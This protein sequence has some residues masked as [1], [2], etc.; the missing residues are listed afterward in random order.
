MSELKKINEYC[1]EVPRSGDMRV[2]GRIYTDESMVKAVHQDGTVKQVSNVAT[3]PGI[4]RASFAMPDVHQGYGFPIGG[5][6]AFDWEEGIVSPGGVGYDISCLLSDARI[7][8]HHGYTFTISEMEKFWP[9]SSLKCRDFKEGVENTTP[10]VGY[11]K[12]PPQNPVYRLTTT[13]GDDILAT[14]DHPFWTPGGMVELE[15][16]TV[17]DNIARYPFEGVPYQAPDNEILVDEEA[18]RSLLAEQGK[19][20]GG[21]ALAQVLNQLKKRDL[22]PLRKDSP[23]LPYLI[24]LAGF[25]M[26]DGCMY[27]T[28]G[29]GKGRT[30]FF[31]EEADLEEIRADV[32]MTGFTPSRIYRRERNHKIRTSYGEFEFKSEE[33]AFKVAGSAF[34]SLLAAIGTPIGRKATQDFCVP[35]WLFNAPRWQ[36]RLFLAAYFGAELSLPKASP[37]K[38]H[39]FSTPILSM[40]KREGFIKSG[41]RFLE[42]I[43]KLLEGFG[44]ET[45]KI[46]QRREQINAD[47]SNS[48]RLRLIFSSKP[49]SLINLWRRVGFEYNRKRQNLGMLAIEYLRQKVRILNRRNEIAAQAIAMAAADVSFPKIFAQL[50]GQGHNINESFLKRAILDERST[51]ARIGMQFETF[52]EFCNHAATGITDSGMVWGTIESLETVDLSE[53]KAYDGYV[54]DFTVAHPDHNFIANGFVVSNCGVRLAT[55]HLEEKDVTPKV[56]ELVTALYQGIPCGVGSKGSVRLS[57]DE[58]KKVLRQGSQWAVKNGFGEKSDIEHTEEGGCLPDADPEL[59]SDRALQRGKKQLGTLGSGNHFIEVGVVEEVF[60]SEA[61]RVFGLFEGQVTVMLHSGSRGLGHQIC[62]DY[63]AFMTKHVKNLPIELPDR[64]LACAMIQSE[65][66]KR[67]LSAMACGANYA[68]AN[69]QIMM[70]KSREIFLQFFGISPRNL[71]MTLLYDVCHNIAKKETHLVDG[72]ER[73]LCVHRK[74]ATRAFPALHPAVPEVYRQMGQPVII[75]GDMGTASYVLVGTHKAMEETFGSTCHGAGRVLSRTAAKKKAK[76]RAIYR[77]LEEKGIFVKSKGKHTMAEE[78]PEAY[79]DISQVIEVVHGAGISKKVAKL[80]PIAVVKG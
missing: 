25:V 27:F 22:L 15:R 13:G 36:Q 19:G 32:R 43:S 39:N 7:L 41:T 5:V 2:P 33:T 57:I 47:G 77:E 65:E 34:A 56:K 42:D 23:Q 60:D 66:G 28:G 38:N 20:D 64:Q 18:V 55:T 44:V 68:W 24:K 14:A 72:K 1:W 12:I 6:A 74:G 50:A 8:N 45:K 35:Q 67:Y 11:L 21:N 62:D 69:R 40:N 49:E 4:V 61:A 30:W 17:G 63:L 73:V 78:M 71:G 26:G 31:G 58:E 51:G 3:L 80:R 75:P 70:H 54:Y 37:K 59:I 46:S 48:H 79:K 29:S 76:G 16:L 53:E 9:M 52:D 10:I